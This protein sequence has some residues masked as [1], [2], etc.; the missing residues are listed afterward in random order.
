MN[1][2]K[3]GVSA[4][5]L[6]LIA[7]LSLGVASSRCAAQWSRFDAV[8]MD[9]GDEGDDSGFDATMMY[10][11]MGA[12][13]EQLEVRPK[14]DLGKRIFQLDF[15]RTPQTVLAA[16]SKLAQKAREKALDPK[17]AEEEEAAEAANA[18][19]AGPGG[20][21]GMPPGMEEMMAPDGDVPAGAAGAAMRAMMQQMAA[22]GGPPG[23]DEPVPGA[24]QPG[25]G[26]K[27]AAPDPNE[28]TKKAEERAKARAKVAMLAERFRLIVTAGDWAGVAAFLKS[29]CGEDAAAIYTFMLAGLER[30]DSALVPGEVLTISGASPG[31]LSDK[32][33]TR[34]GNLLKACHRRGSEPATVAAE[35]SRGTTHFGGSEPANRKRAAGLLIAA[36]LPIEAAAYLPPVEEARAGGDAELLIFHAVYFHAL[37][38]TQQGEERQG[39]MT[40]SWALVRE[41][42]GMEKA[43]TE[44]REKGL[45]LALGLLPDLPEDE[46]NEWIVSLFRGQPDLAWKAVDVS[47]AGASALRARQAKPEQRIKALV[48]LR[49]LG[50]GLLAAAGESLGDWRGA[51]DMMTMTI[52]DEAEFTKQA[53]AMEAEMNRY[54]PYGGNENRFKPIPPEQLTALMPDPAWLAAIDPGLA[55]KLELMVAG[56]QTTAGDSDGVMSMVKRVVASDPKRALKLAQSLLESW[57]A[58]VKQ[59]A[60][61][62]MDMYAG[63]SPM[64]GYSP[65][66]VGRSYPRYGGYGYR[67]YSGGIPLTRAKQR[68][69]LEQFHHVLAELSVL[70]VGPLP[71]QPL[72]NAFA[73]S[74]S[75]AEVFRMEDVEGVFGPLESVPAET[76]LALAESMRRR[77]ATI[78]RRPQVQ[79]ANN[80]RRNDKELAV[81]VVRGYAL[82]RE[83]VP[84]PGDA[85]TRAWEARA[86]SADLSFDLAEFLYGQNA[87][88]AAYSQA[89]EQAFAEYAAAAGLYA[90]AIEAGSV[91]PTARVYLQWF[92]ASQGASDL[93]SMT[94]QD[95]PDTNQSEAVKAA[96][97]ALPEAVARK[98]M[99][100]FALGCVGALNEL[101][102]ELRP[103]F[104]RQA[105]AIVGDHPDGTELRKRLAYYND[106][107]REIE[108]NL[109]VDGPTGVG[110][111]APFGVKLGVWTTRAVARESGGFGK[112]LMNDQYHPATGQPV[113]YKD[114]LEK[115]I[116]DTLG[117]KFEIVALRFHKP[118]VEPGGIAREGWE[119][120]PLAYLL[121][122]P[123]D[124]SVDRIPP[125]KMDMD[126]NDSGGFVILPVASGVALIDARDDA[127]TPAAP[128]GVEIEQTLDDRKLAEGS[129]TLEVRAKGKGVLPPLEG[130]V[131]RG[132]MKRFGVAKVDDHG[133]SI[134]DLD[135]T[136][137]RVIPITE[138]S[139]TLTLAPA[140]DSG[141]IDS[142]TFPTP[143][144]AD[145]KLT[146]KRYSDADIVDARAVVPIPAYRPP[147]KRRWYA[148]GGA[149]LVLVGGVGAVLLAKRRRGIE[150]R[151][152]LFALPDDVTPMGT[153]SLLRRILALNGEVLAAGDQAELGRDIA[154]LEH[155]YFAPQGAT[156]ATPNGDAD[157]RPLLERW[158]A[159]VNR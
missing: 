41:A 28:M 64:M 87:D 13:G 67:N 25:A 71:A 57:P 33:V 112:Y 97:N 126:F 45:R 102:P 20:G 31:E 74:H 2:L 117:E 128:T 30:S 144:L 83:I 148:A 152:P 98:H 1:G 124:A 62:E 134:A 155:R 107:V 114:D 40:K 73:A 127:A 121:L 115:K 3:S 80:T 55:A 37:A 139:W 85:G 17:K 145:A 93:G 90:E 9:G 94:R 8:S 157:L 32:N 34:L 88:L 42:L 119:E 153:I 22:A 151:P 149:A 136:T 156:G 75:D 69:N 63:Y 54:N 95:K 140:G 82:A 108:L 77:L 79:Q 81:E 96:L 18:E 123:R 26:D 58:Y 110:H 11:R 72:V 118:E 86:A 103:R 76:R 132:A 6:A 43:S 36:D 66:G 101:A 141:V 29:E 68:R 49:R 21:P 150:E 19:N 52:L 44:Q 113:N 48:V 100:L 109:S 46:G 111:A 120:F 24:D 12:R 143:R 154:S 104:A 135:T 51:L 125:V 59:G 133:L 61:P 146:L 131:D 50:K 84:D 106:L 23:A 47:S 99:G 138:R 122:K 16:R 137:P 39:S 147:D 142:F 92:N 15:T 158:V 27:P 56:T 5:M 105:V 65:Y 129:V 89:R 78:W 116:R 7:G 159:R 130:L 53:R 10:P 14:T 38:K 70:K 35:I 60:G 4:S 91:Q